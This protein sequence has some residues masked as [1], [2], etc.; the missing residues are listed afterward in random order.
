MSWRWLLYRPVGLRKPGRQ[1]FGHTRHSYDSQS[2]LVVGHPIG[3]VNPAEL[4][5][6]PE[7]VRMVDEQGVSLTR[8][9]KDDGKFALENIWPSKWR[10]QKL[11]YDPYLGER[12]LTERELL[13]AGTDSHVSERLAFVVFRSI[14]YA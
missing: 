5:M 11:G 9:L 13:I 1:N 7:A 8:K 4:P 10:L 6:M 14:T 2:G 3:S 12:I